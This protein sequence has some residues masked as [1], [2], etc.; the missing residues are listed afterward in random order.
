MRKRDKTLPY[1]IGDG[2][3][4][5]GFGP[6]PGVRVDRRVAGGCDGSEWGGD[7]RSRISVIDL[8]KG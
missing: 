2:G 5:V 7:C 8:A 6:C 3:D 1:V 4:P